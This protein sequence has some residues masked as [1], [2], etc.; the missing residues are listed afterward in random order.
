MSG[1]SISAPD[2]THIDE[3]LYRNPPFRTDLRV[4]F[5]ATTPLIRRY[6]QAPALRLLYQVVSRVFGGPQLAGTRLPARRYERQLSGKLPHKRMRWAAWVDP[7][8]PFVINLPTAG[9][10]DRLQIR[11]A[12]FKDN[13]FIELS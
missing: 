9:K 12:T 6:C 1:R 7:K 3:E 8:L 4:Q 2:P 10:C 13:R 5:Q 11:A